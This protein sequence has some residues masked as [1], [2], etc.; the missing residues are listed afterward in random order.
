[1]WRKNKKKKEE[2]ESKKRRMIWTG[3][4]IGDEG[5]EMISEV[6]KSNST[7]IHLGL[8]CEEKRKKR[9]EKKVSKKRR[10]I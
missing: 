5:T 4:H 6:L 2:K 8:S 9:K 3:N 7:L 10:M 1:M